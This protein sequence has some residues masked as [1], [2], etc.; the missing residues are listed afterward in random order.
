MKRDTVRNVSF[1]FRLSDIEKQVLETMALLE[2][3]SQSEMLRECIREAAIK[4]GL[5]MLG[6]IQKEYK[7][8]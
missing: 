1:I 6:L 7:K 2:A 4:R 3:R 5:G 8:R